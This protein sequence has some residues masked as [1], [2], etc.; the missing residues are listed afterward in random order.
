MSR[1]DA[2][3]KEVKALYEDKHPERADWA[4]WL[5]EGHVRVV[6]EKAEAIAKRFGIDPELSQASALLHDIADATMKREN[7]K[8]GETSLQMAREMLAEHDFTEEEIAILVD[9]AIALHSCID[10]KKPKNDIGRVLATADA[11]AHLE[12]DFYYFAAYM[13]G[14]QGKSFAEIRNW[15]QQK[16]ERDYHD[17]ICF[18]E[19]KKELEATY[20]F[21]HHAFQ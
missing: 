9:D 8:H 2:L 5:W 21:L 13:F 12:T 18:P 16:I 17:K 15:I 7:P 11:L 3:R 4:D 10:G 14:K 1:L 19:I 6:T 20:R